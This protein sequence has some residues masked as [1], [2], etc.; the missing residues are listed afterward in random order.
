[1][2]DNGAQ[3]VMTTSVKRKQMWLV[4]VSTTPEVLYAMQQ[5]ES[6]KEQVTMCMTLLFQSLYLKI[7][8]Y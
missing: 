2:M 5:E 7:H 3:S 6:H 8:P 4:T 1:M